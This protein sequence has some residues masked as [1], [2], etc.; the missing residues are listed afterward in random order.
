MANEVSYEEREDDEDHEVLGRPFRVRARLY[1]NRLI[2]ARVEL[3]FHTAA[4]AARGLGLMVETIRN[5]EKLA[6]S[7]VAKNTGDWRASAQELADALGFA[8]EDLWPDVIF[9]VKQHYMELEAG[10]QMI[11]L[12]DGQD[13]TALT[14]Q[15][16]RALKVLP[17]R[18][19][20]IVVRHFGLA[21]KEE[22]DLSQVG[23]ALKISRER[24]RQIELRALR[25]LRVE[26]AKDEREDYSPG[27]IWRRQWGAI[28]VKVGRAAAAA[29]LRASQK[30]WA[31]QWLWLYE[32][33]W[34]WGAIGRVVNAP[35]DPACSGSPD[36][37]TA[38]GKYIKCPSCTRK[39]KIQPNGYLAYHHR[40]VKFSTDNR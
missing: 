39:T 4:E 29:A 37:F 3:G 35:S 22:H 9:S 14:A 28:W 23:E 13:A 24:V 2:K 32:W 16:Q 33:G 30:R 8:P 21:G 38:V 1:N 27:H 25:K 15:V 17:P 18:E 10:S 5:Y 11:A 19:H 26:I 12:D 6:T 40:P 31:R 34:A 7:P 36:L 20:E